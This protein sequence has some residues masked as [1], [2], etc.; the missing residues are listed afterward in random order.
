MRQH[1]DYRE[2]SQE[3]S[4]MAGHRP[5]SKGH[6]WRLDRPLSRSSPRHASLLAPQAHFS[7]PVRRGTRLQHL[8]LRP[9][10]PLA[11]SNSPKGSSPTRRPRQH[12]RLPQQHRHTQR[13]LRRRRNLAP[14]VPVLRRLRRGALP[15]ECQTRRERRN[16]RARPSSI[17]VQSR[18]RRRLSTTG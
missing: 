10:S 3:F 4:P 6:P 8:P 15:L 2:N 12:P 7:R 17:H 5:C 18:R 14:K 16:N 9:T 13:L 1:L 11:A